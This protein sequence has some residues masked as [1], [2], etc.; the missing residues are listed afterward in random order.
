MSEYPAN[1]VD[2]ASRE[3]R[4]GD[5]GHV[6]WV[7]GPIA[8]TPGIVCDVCRDTACALCGRFAMRPTH[9]YLL[10]RFDELTNRLS[11]DVVV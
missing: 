10:E 2:P 9:P 7:G 4:C 8:P 5:C 1:M 6:D 11:E 3:C